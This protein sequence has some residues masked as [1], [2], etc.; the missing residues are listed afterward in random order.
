MVFLVLRGVHGFGDKELARHQ[1]FI[2]C[3]VLS[4]NYKVSTFHQSFEN[5]K[6]QQ[7]Q[8]QITTT[9]NEFPSGSRQLYFSSLER[10]AQGN[11][12]VMV[13]ARRDITHLTL[14]MKSITAF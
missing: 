13:P 9:T 3:R 7:Q 8:Q 4:N 6:R 10:T 2:L 11:A 5:T 1:P 12:L 14:S